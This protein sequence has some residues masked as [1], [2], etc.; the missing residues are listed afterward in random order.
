MAITVH[1]PESPGTGEAANA[2]ARLSDAEI[3]DW[4]GIPVS[5]AVDLAPE[6]QIDPAIALRTRLSAGEEAGLSLRG[7]ALTVR[8]DP[9][10]FGAV[11]LA[12][13]HV[14]VGDVVVIAAQARTD[15][16]M[17]GEILGGH[18]RSKGCAGLVVDGAVRDIDQLGSWS[19]FPVFARAVNPLGPTSAAGGVLNGPIEAGGCN[20]SPGD[21]I[22]GDADGLIAL[23][24]ALARA[25]LAGARAKL[26]LEQRWISQLAAGQSAKD[27]FGL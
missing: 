23:N 18:L 4:A 13:D 19:D 22:L 6:G 8:C 11:V 3:S 20:I 16:A 25:R 24:P 9:P 15:F 1:N 10:D 21:L 7:R 17:I 26:E 12:L 2:P 14:Q 27:V 5:V